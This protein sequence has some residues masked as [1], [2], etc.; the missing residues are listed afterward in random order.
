[1]LALRIFTSTFFILCSLFD[2]L[3]GHCQADR[4]FAFTYLIRKARTRFTYEL[5]IAV[6]C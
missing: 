3:Y 2:I 6:D 5:L 4:F 1:M